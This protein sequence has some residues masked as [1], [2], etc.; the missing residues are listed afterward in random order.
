MNGTNTWKNILLLFI[1]GALWGSSFLLTEI[2]LESM[3]PVTFTTVRNLL[4]AIGLVGLLYWKNGR[5]PTAWRSWF[6]YLLLGLFNTAIPF[7]LISW[8]QLYIDSGLASILVSTMPLFTIILAHFF[9]SS[10][11][12]TLTK[13]VGIM[14]GLV[15]IVVLIDP[16]AL[17]GLGQN[18]LGQLAVIG[19]AIC[20]A[21]GAIHSLRVLQAP[22][23]RALSQQVRAFE[24]IAGQF[25]TTAVFFI[26]IALFV[27]GLPTL[28]SLRSTLALFGSAWPM[29]I[30]AV[31]VFYYLIDTVSTTF[32]SLSVYLIP[33]FGVLFGVLILNEPLTLQIVVAL[34]LILCGVAIVNGIFNRS[35]QLSVASNQ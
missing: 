17:E 1:P 4:T 28:P 13:F 29:T 25:V 6:D 31:V 15:G 32:A 10:E 12:I 8:G 16:S 22:R 19:A 35:N 27:D 30:I 7:V 14:L 34:C 18:M 33:I 23:L 9:T 2:V 20:Y 5:L 11:R 26:P 3:P 24:V 21:I